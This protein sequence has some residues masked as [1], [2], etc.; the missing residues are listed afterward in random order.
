MVLE[1]ELESFNKS[2]SQPD[3]EAQVTVKKADYE[4]MKWLTAVSSTRFTGAK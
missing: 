1:S 4:R 2:D 3:D